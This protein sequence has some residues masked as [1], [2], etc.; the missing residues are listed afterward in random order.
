MADNASGGGF[1]LLPRRFSWLPQGSLRL[2]LNGERV[3]E[4]PVEALGDP[5]ERLAWL[6]G[7]VGGLRAGQVVFLGSPAPAVPLMGGV[8]ELW[9]EGG[10]LLARV[11]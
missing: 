6:A 4:G 2:Y 1:L 8:L 3:A 7:R 5:G 9:G 11:E 10:V